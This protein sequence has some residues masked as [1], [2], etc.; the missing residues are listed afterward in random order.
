MFRFSSSVFINWS[1]LSSSAPLCG[2]TRA[3]APHS[4]AVITGLH[5][6]H[7]TRPWLL[8][9]TISCSGIL[10][11][12]LHACCSANCAAETGAGLDSGREQEAP[13]LQQCFS[14]HQLSAALP[15]N[16][17]QLCQH[18]ASLPQSGS[19]RTASVHTDCPAGKRS[20]IVRRH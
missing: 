17:D 1:F 8:P 6:C 10:V 16:T 14:R 2:P 7:S 15:V 11:F 13:Q 19:I 4:S 3:G 18:T 5:W 20:W 12:W 9:T